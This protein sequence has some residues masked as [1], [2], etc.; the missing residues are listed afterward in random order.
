MGLG[1]FLCVS[2]NKEKRRYFC[3]SL[4]WGENTTRHGTVSPNKICIKYA[5]TRVFCVESKC[6]VMVLGGCFQSSPS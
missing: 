5:W 4:D 6:V 3:D 1:F 2:L